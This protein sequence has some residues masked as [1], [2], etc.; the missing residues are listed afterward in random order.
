MKSKLSLVVAGLCSLAMGCA[1]EEPW[2]LSE[3]STTSNDWAEAYPVL[4]RDCAFFA[5]HGS[6]ERLFQVWGPKR[7]RLFEGNLT[8][9]EE[10]ERIGQESEKTFQMALGFVDINDPGRSLL[11]RK[12]LDPQAG[13]TGHLGLDKF[14]RN[15]Y[16]SG[17]SPGYVQLAKWVYS[18]RPKADDDGF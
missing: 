11:L 6:S 10:R 12:G 9:N 17:D 8:G 18:L 4:L 5:C 16:R 15:V 14:G 7:R 13:G 2:K 3:A 1:D